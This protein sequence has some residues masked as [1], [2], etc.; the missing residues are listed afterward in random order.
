[1]IKAKVIFYQLFALK[2]F[3]G[4]FSSFA[5]ST[6]FSP[7]SLH[8]HNSHYFL[9]RGEPTVFITSAEHYGALLNLDFDFRKY[10]DTLSEEGMNMTRIFSGAYCEPDG[11]FNIS[12]NTLAP[13]EGKFIAPWKRSG[14]TGYKN[15]GNKFDLNRWDEAYFQRLRNLVRYASTK[16]VAVEFTFFCPMYAEAQWE[17]SPMNIQNNV[18]GV[19]KLDR[20]DVYN[21][22]KNGDLL[23]YQEAL[24]RKLVRELN[25]FDNVILEI[26]NEP[27]FGGV[28]ME[29]QH[30]IADIMVETESTLPNKHL[31]SQNIANNKAL[32]LDPH[33]A[34]SVFNFHYATPPEAVGMN[35]HWNRV[36]GDNE[37]GFRGNADEPYRKEAWD[38]IL[39]GGGLFNHLDYS[40]ATGFEDGRYKYPSTQPGGGNTG[41][42]QQMRALSEFIQSFDFIQMR[43]DSSVIVGGIP[44]GGTAR[45][46]VKKNEAIAIY[47]VNEG[48]TGPWSVRWTGMIQC[49]SDGEYSFHTFSNDGVRLWLDNQLLI[50]NWTD[51]GETEDIAKTTLSK[52]RTKSVKLEYFYNGGQGVM[53]LWWTRPDGVKEPVP[54]N[55]FRLPDGKGWGLRGQYFKTRDL[56]QKWKQRDDGTI[57]FKWGIKPPFS[58]G[59]SDT[60]IPLELNL[61]AGSWSA[62]WIDTID[63]S[64]KR[65]MNILG[66]T[67]I[68]L[69]PPVYKTDI[70]LRVLKN[71][72]DRSLAH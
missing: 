35:F 14:V 9:W 53:K 32:I 6:S 41:F 8:P 16:G 42:R 62:E 65:S 57:D 1:M 66:G 36:I 18:N 11:A 54:A 38:F 21:L 43:P 29:W 44:E 26:A 15:G 17:L 70:A 71:T 19:G 55:A 27:Y 59:N 45:A 72:N 61:P 60:Q 39:A 7:I 58:G 12:R 28:T 3:V 49:P 31:I 24:T 22:Q 46:L 69:M 5:A 68:K 47:M 50:N 37:T 64:I 48:T 67:V 34:I 40:F 52:N 56:K 2:M 20:N 30:H 23:A 33:P 13:L 63:G 51:H 10:I 4:C 25:P